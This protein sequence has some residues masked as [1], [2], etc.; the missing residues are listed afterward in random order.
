MTTLWL[1]IAVLF[2]IPT[3]STNDGAIAYYYVR[4]F[5]AHNV[6]RPDQSCLTFNEYAR[7][8]DK[9]FLD[10]TSFIFLSGLHELS[11]QLWLETLQTLHL[12][13]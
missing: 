8:K 12:M 10:G 9:Y 5:S 13:S 2:R 4:P 6:T 3:A 1:L 11:L 7:E